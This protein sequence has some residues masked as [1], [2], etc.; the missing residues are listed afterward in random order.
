M[1]FLIVYAG[2]RLLV[3][4]VAVQLRGER[5]VRLELIVLRQEI[6][7][8]RRRT[9]R[10]GWRPTDRLVLA[11]LSRY[12][13]EICLGRLP[14]AAGD[15]ASLASGTGPAQMGALR[16]TASTRTTGRFAGMP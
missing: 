13:P 15:A 1:F 3:D 6:R 12:L 4:L 11:A 16:S 14:C 8:C 2:F 10:L 7:M 9:N 5:A